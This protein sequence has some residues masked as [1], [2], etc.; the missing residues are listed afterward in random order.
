LSGYWS[1]G[2]ATVRPRQ[3]CTSRYCR[4]AT[5]T[6]GKTL[7]TLALLAERL[8]VRVTISPGSDAPEILVEDAFPAA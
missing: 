8:G 2:K 4:R 1:A 6:S 5:R 3:A 7:T